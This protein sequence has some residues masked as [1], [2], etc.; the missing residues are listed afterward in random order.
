[1]V[2]YINKLTVHKVQMIT[3]RL[4]SMNITYGMFH[5]IRYQAG[6]LKRP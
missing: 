4:N 5:G 1:M 2:A 6:D 3:G